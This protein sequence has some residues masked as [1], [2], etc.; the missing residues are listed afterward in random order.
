MRH[1]QE[2]V[3]LRGGKKMAISV[4]LEFK[5]AVGVFPEERANA[6]Y[7]Q[8]VGC[9]VDI[10]G[11]C[12]CLCRS[13]TEED[14]E[15]RQVE[16]ACE[17]YKRDSPEVDSRLKCLKMIEVPEDSEYIGVELGGHNIV[18]FNDETREIPEFDPAMVFSIEEYFKNTFRDEF[19]VFNGST[20]TYTHQWVG[21]IEEELRRFTYWSVMAKNK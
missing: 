16:R 1:I 12:G 4:Y 6:I 18:A 14:E 21:T 15:L 20:Y 2:S 19:V 9:D 13:G 8:L 5:V 10:Y 17:S 7:K 3:Y 11:V